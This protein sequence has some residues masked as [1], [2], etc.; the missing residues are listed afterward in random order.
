VSGTRDALVPVGYEPIRELGRGGLGVV[1]LARHVGLGRLCAVKRLVVSSDHESIGRFRREAR[2]LA[3]LDHPNVVRLYD[4]AAVEGRLFVVMEYVDGTDLGQLLGADNLDPLRAVSVLID[5]AAA[6]DHAASR[7]VVHRDVKPSNVFVQ[8]SGRAKLGDFGIARILGDSATYRSVVG[9]VAGSAAYMAP[10]QFLGDDIGPATDVY[11][12]A[13]LAYELTVGRR[14]FDGDS[15]EAVVDGHLH[16]IPPHPG[17]LVADY[18]DV[19]AEVLL[20]GL[21]KAPERRPTVGEIAAALTAVVPGDWPR[22]ERAGHGLAIA[23]CLTEPPVATAIAA[24]RA[25]GAAS[26]RAI[27]PSA[28]EEPPRPV[29]GWVDAPVFRPVP[30]RRS[31]LGWRWALAAGVVLGATGSLIVAN[32]R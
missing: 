25:R 16:G 23:P 17:R 20:A 28:V 13:V 26:D 24:R 11:G 2:A 31:R 22:P 14:P 9:S 15:R 32:L 7:G 6:L 8:A 12:L 18:P 4:V 5:V 1:V 27:V 10:E 19:V 29:D 21:A 30:S 3:R